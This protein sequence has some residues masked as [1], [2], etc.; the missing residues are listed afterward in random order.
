MFYLTVNYESKS[1]TTPSNEQTNNEN[2]NNKSEPKDYYI[3]LSDLYDMYYDLPKLRRDYNLSEI[4]CRAN[5]YIYPRF[6]KRLQKSFVITGSCDFSDLSQFGY[7]PLKA[8]IVLPKEF[9]KYNN[10]TL[11][12]ELLNKSLKI[13]IAANGIATAK[14]ATKEPHMIY[15]NVKPPFY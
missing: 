5:L 9:Y 3:S 14:L 13:K 4:R 6:K 7:V 1:A 12:L 11:K 2:S 8:V 15:R 10:F